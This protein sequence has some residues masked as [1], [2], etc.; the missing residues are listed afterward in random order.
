MGETK[1][2]T[3][4]L[5]RHGECAENRD[6]V[7]RGRR[8]VPLNENGIRQ[9][10]ALAEELQRYA[11][12]ALFTS[13]LERAKHTALVIGH[14]AG[15]PV[16]ERSGFTNMALGPWE[17][18]PKALIRETYPEEWELWLRH[19]ERLALPGAETLDDVQRRAF[20]NLEHL[21]RHRSGTTFAVVTHRAVIKPLLAAC[22]DIQP[23]A[24]WRLH[25]DTASYSVLFHEEGRGYCCTLLNQTRH[26]PDVVSEWV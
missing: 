22:L 8:D 12:T 4:L 25:V 7:F 11:P 18:Q 26:L 17:G 16:E 15:I 21:V 6:G 23:P 14:R 19:P 10:E 24:F 1:R 3:I 20:A 5:V 9:A 2:T 13:P